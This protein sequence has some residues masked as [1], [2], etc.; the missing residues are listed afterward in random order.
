[1]LGVGG[2]AGGVH[3]SACCGC[4]PTV[5]LVPHPPPHLHT[6]SLFRL[7]EALLQLMLSR[8]QE[9]W[10]DPQL[11]LPPERRK[12][13]APDLLQQPEAGPSWVSRAQACMSGCRRCGW[14]CLAPGCRCCC[15]ACH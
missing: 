15:P 2:L 1:M 9:D 3:S 8:G 14:R 11:L 4:L 12:A 7:Q 13:R 10:G 5:S 6:C